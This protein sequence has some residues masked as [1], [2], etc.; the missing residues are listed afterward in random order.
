MTVAP[1]PVLDLVPVDS[2]AGAATAA[3]QRRP[4]AARRAMRISPPPVRRAPSDHPDE[5]VVTTTAHD[6]ADHAPAAGGFGD[7]TTLGHLSG[8]RP[9]SITDEG[10]HYHERRGL[11]P[12]RSG[13]EKL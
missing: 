7:R 6:R 3:R 12:A 9:E 10:H 4:G 8:G 5:L 2:G 13:A 11:P 1:L